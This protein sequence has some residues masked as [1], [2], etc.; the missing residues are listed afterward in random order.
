LEKKR[1]KDG[2]HRQIKIW[3]KKEKERN[4]NKKRRREIY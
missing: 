2:R 1:G 3:R 4:K